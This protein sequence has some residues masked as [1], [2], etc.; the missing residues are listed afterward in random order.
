M[1]GSWWDPFDVWRDLA[2]QQLTALLRI[3]IA[4]EK[5]NPPSKQEPPL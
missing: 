2:E 5:L 4:L 1:T 3:A